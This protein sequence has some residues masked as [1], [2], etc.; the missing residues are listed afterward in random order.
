M[1]AYFWIGDPACFDLAAPLRQIRDIAN[2][3]IDEF[4]KVQSQR[5]YAQE[6]LEGKRKEVEALVI[7]IRNLSAASMDELVG[8]L[9]KTRA[10]Q[11]AVIELLNIKYMAVDEVNSLKEILQQWN[12]SLSNDTVAFLL[13]ENSL[14]PYE[15]KVKRQQEL[16]AGITK[17]VDAKP[18]ETAM[19]AIAGELEMLID[20]LGSL[21]I[22]DAT[23][24]T[25]II[26]KISL[27]FASLNEAKADLARMTAQLKTKESA[28]EFHAQLTLLDQS[29]VNFLAMSVT[30]E[31]CDDYFTRISVQVEELESRFAD[32]DDFVLTLADKR[33]E[34]NK[35]FNSRRSAWRNALILSAA[36]CALLCRR[37][38]PAQI[39][40]T[41]TK[42]LRCFCSKNRAGRKGCRPT[43]RS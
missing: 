6:Q 25:R 15:E 41:P 2:T 3:A 29:M 35:A 16:A 18:V 43:A 10:M 5:K 38:R 21:R 19:G 11:G 27:I 14:A 17:V 34:V 22:E 32:F 13:K 24:T 7:S 20:I 39:S 23:Q 1:D 31:K 30:P 12:L 4:A 26:E 40:C 36:G 9:G 8:M 37:S 42:P 28:G 33:E